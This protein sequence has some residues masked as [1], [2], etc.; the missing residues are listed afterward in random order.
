MLQYVIISEMAHPYKK[1]NL[2]IPHIEAGSLVQPAEL[3]LV[4]LATAN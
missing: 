4:V 2:H 3:V 1:V